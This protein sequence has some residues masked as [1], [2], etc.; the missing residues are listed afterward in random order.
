[1]STVSALVDMLR[2]ELASESS[3]HAPTIAALAITI[4]IVNDSDD[5]NASVEL[6]RVAYVVLRTRHLPPSSAMLG[7]DVASLE[8][9]SNVGEA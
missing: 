3:Q 1:M 6:V 7:S 2:A 5:G 8:P 4:I 9:A